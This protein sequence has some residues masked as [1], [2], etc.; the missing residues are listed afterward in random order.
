[1]VED[2]DLSGCKNPGPADIYRTVRWSNSEYVNLVTR[3]NAPYTR[4]LHVAEHSRD[5]GPGK[6]TMDVKV[7]G[8]AV[9]KDFDPA[10]AGWMKAGTHEVKGVMS[11]G[12]GRIVL[13]F[14]GGTRIGNEQ[15]DPRINGYELIPE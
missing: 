15:R 2:V 8:K 1:M 12:E 11:D 13:K 4:R 9:V 5:Q 10:F 14:E 3:K 7:N 6:N